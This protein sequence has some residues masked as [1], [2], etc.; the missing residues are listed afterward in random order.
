MPETRRVERIMMK[1]IARH[2]IEWASRGPG[3]TKLRGYR[4]NAK[5]PIGDEQTALAPS[6]DRVS[7]TATWPFAV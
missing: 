5:N 2:W 7:D 3:L 4:I 6:G 1:R